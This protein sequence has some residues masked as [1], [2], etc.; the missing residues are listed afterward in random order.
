MCRK[1]QDATTGNTKTKM[2]FFQW[3]CSR[4]W[5]LSNEPKIWFLKTKIW[6]TGQAARWPH[7]TS[8][9]QTQSVFFLVSFTVITFFFAQMS[10]AGE[11]KTP[12]GGKKK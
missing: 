11:E 5:F 8:P 12:E 10:T 9:V 3:G 2:Q 4:F 6:D 1:H 7:G